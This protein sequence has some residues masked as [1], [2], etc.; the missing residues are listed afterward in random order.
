[1][2]FRLL[3]TDGTAVF[4]PQDSCQGPPTI[5]YWSWH[6]P[7]AADGLIEGRPGA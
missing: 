4:A 2:I 3:E 7:R 6:R 1:M 5:G